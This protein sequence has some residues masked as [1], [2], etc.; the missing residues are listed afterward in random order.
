MQN[1]EKAIFAENWFTEKQQKQRFRENNT[2]KHTEKAH[3]DRN[4]CKHSEKEICTT[5]REAT[6][7]GIHRKNIRKYL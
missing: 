7:A 2:Q 4:T 5:Y 3:K 1:P 6:F